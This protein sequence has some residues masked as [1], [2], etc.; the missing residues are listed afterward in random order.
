MHSSIHLPHVG[1]KK[2]HTWKSVPPNWES[3]GGT[4]IGL[5]IALIPYHEHALIDALYDV[6]DPRSQSYG[7]HFS[8]EQVA[9]L[10][11]P[12]PHTLELIYSWLGHHDVPL[13]SISTL[14]S[15]GCL[16][17]TGVPVPQAN[18]LLG[19]SYQLY[20]RT[21]TN[22]TAI[23]RTIGYALPTV[24][25]THV[26]TVIPTTYLAATR[27]LRRPPRRRSVG[28][29]ADMTSRKLLRTPPSKDDETT[30]EE[31]RWLYRTVYYVPAAT[32]KNVLG[33]A[34]FLNEYPSPADS[35]K[36]LT[37]F[38]EDAADAAFTVELI[39]KGK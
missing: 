19:A 38:R 35:K 5:Y 9:E 21:G 2:G 33:V 1:S 10:V 37:E 23:L 32:D 27:S 29:A 25:H 26:R 34:G 22:E 36:F 24:L 39:N 17:V 13:F 31:L 3:L 7:A 20:W 8:K 4:T 18:E 16:K 28:V 11:A 14:H 6:S 15:G 30:P 12:H